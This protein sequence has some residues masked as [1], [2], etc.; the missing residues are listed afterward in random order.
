[1]CQILGK[2]STRCWFCIGRKWS[3]SGWGCDLARRLMMR[4]PALFWMGGLIMTLSTSLGETVRDS[5]AESTIE[6]EEQKWEL[7][8][9]TSTYFVQDGRDFVNPTITADRDWLHLEAR[10]NY[11]SLN[12]G[13]FWLGYNFGFGDKLA[14]EITPML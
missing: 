10:Y 3:R 5:S 1:M 6:A 8:L 7:S 14:F 4:F 13:S 9:S 12:T 2:P 11:E